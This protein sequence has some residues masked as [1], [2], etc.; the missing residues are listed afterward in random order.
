MLSCRR[1]PETRWNVAAVWAAS[2][3]DWNPGRSAIMNLIR[4]VTVASA[5]A[6]THGSSQNSPN[7]VSIPVK[8]KRSAASATWAR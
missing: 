4:S 2:S 3:G 6:T 8:P 1:A 5:D 7:G